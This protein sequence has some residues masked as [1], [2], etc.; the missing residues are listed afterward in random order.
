[1]KKHTAS[2]LWQGSIKEGNGTIST[3]SKVLESSNYSFGS[4]FGDDPATNPDE[5]LAAAHAG[6]YVMALSLILGEAG[7]TPEKLGAKAEITMDP[8][9][10]SI[11]QS[12]I[13]LK[14]KIP[15]ISQ[16]KFLECANAAKESCPISK[17]LNIPISL[18]AT[19]E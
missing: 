17:A 9:I 16:E 6:C 19:L 2:A 4:R 14:G 15:G 7:F 12:H 1:M 3:R 18:D 5:L 11:T 10:L 13:K 8:S